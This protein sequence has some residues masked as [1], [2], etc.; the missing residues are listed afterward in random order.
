MPFEDLDSRF[1]GMQILSVGMFR[2]LV[3]GLLITGIRRNEVC[4][5]FTLIFLAYL[6]YQR[7]Y[8]LAMRGGTNV[9]TIYYQRWY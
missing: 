8:V 3:S 5:I 1:G 9:G 6:Q 4:K 2:S 7:W